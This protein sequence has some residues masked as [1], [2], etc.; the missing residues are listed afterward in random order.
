[1]IVRHT[2]QCL[3]SLGKDFIDLRMIND[4]S[5]LLHEYCWKK[6]VGFQF[7]KKKVSNDKWVMAWVFKRR[8]N[9]FSRILICPT[10]SLWPI[11]PQ[12]SA[13][14]AVKPMLPCC[15]FRA[16]HFH[17]LAWCFQDACSSFSQP[18][19]HISPLCLPI[20]L[21]CFQNEMLVG[22]WQCTMEFLC[23]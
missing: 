3:S 2:G 9:N 17:L 1:M 22:K 6:K 14:A 7:K 16:S 19:R 5:L 15:S 4:N 20:S 18:G 13:L 10:F 12:C 8:V 21:S 11:L 23:H